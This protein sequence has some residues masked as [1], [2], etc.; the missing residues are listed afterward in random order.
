[1]AKNH[2]ATRV[3]TERHY[4]YECKATAQERPYVSRPS[5]SQQLRNPKLV[6]KLTNETLNPLEKKEGVAD[7][8]LAKVD[9]ERA[10]K[11][12]REERD[13]ELI[14]SSAKRHRSVSSHSVSTI[15]TE[16]DHPVHVEEVL[17]LTIH[18][19]EMTFE[20]GVAVSAR[21][22]AK[23][24][25]SNLNAGNLCLAMIVLQKT[26][27]AAIT[28]DLAILCPQVEKLR[29]R[30]SREGV[31]RGHGVHMDTGASV[32]K[33]QGRQGLAED[34]ARGL[35]RLVPDMAVRDQHHA[36]DLMER[37]TATEVAIKRMHESEV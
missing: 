14:N 24:L 35:V 19:A 32:L 37:E 29:L 11:R 12:E 27:I 13:D 3:K 2:P 30:S 10:R 26:M 33:A 36:E 1:M 25:V 31:H 23:V 9:A 7:A 20:A 8:E 15:S 21:T 22:A 18:E 4:S 17:I 28:I 16:L 5:R 34:T 6:P